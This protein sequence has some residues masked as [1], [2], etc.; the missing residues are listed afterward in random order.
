MLPV[1]LLAV[2]KAQDCLGPVCQPKQ[3][4]HTPCGSWYSEHARPGVPR[5]AE[6]KV[7]FPRDQTHQRR[8]AREASGSCTR[9]LHSPGPADNQQNTGSLL[10]LLDDWISLT[11]KLDMHHIRIWANREITKCHCC[12]LFENAVME[13]IT[14]CFNQ[15]M[16]NCS[17]IWSAFGLFKKWCIVTNRS[18][19]SL[20][21]IYLCDIFEGFEFL[22]WMF[23]S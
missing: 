13:P 20:Q 16:W 10:M 5:G 8:C 15:N 14:N 6:D 21:L 23:S 11:Q 9:L 22:Q 17:H 12:H 2:Q 3:C 18:S 7:L 1:F 19:T 4:N